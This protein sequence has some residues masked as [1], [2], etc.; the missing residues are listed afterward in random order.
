MIKDIIITLKKTQH[1]PQK[2]SKMS[3]MSN[4]SFKN[5]S[6]RLSIMKLLAKSDEILKKP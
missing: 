5:T 1:L 3:I 6:T 4:L 2:G